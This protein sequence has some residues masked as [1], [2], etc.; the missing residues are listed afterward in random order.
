M[1]LRD[2]RSVRTESIDEGARR[3]VVIMPQ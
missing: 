1:A 2:H 3:K